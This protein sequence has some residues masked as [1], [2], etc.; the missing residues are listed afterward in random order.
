MNNYQNVAVELCALMET[1]QLCLTPY[2]EFS[3]QNK[4]WLTNGNP[5][6]NQVEIYLIQPLYEANRKGLLQLSYYGVLGIIQKG[7]ALD[8]QVL[9]DFSYF[10]KNAYKYYNSWWEEGVYDQIASYGVLAKEGKINLTNSDIK[11]QEKEGITIVKTHNSKAMFDAIIYSESYY[12][13]IIEE[14]Q[15]F[16]SCLKEDLD[17]Q[18]MPKL[19]K[20]ASGE[21]RIQS[22][23]GMDV[24]NEAYLKEMYQ[25]MLLTAIYYNVEYPNMPKITVSARHTYLSV[26]HYIVE[27]SEVHRLT[28]LDNILHRFLGEYI[29]FENGEFSLKEKY[30]NEM[31]PDIAANFVK[32]HVEKC[33]Q[34]SH[35]ID[36]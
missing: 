25:D 36:K 24:S 19:S 26:G 28:L 22:R 7:K 34:S 32:K 12:K 5:P 33:D 31:F 9:A 11:N 18:L 35:P 8:K 2:Y 13:T 29:D 10:L 3:Q 20:V 21:L 14:N 4:K 16:G 27:C 17:I 15:E 23:G 6:I 30:T 1:E